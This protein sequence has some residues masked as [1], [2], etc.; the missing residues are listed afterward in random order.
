MILI[1]TYFESLL[2]LLLKY[3]ILKTKK[4]RSYIIIKKNI[5]NIKTLSIKILI[6]LLRYILLKSLIIINYLI[7]SLISRLL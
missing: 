3:I 2:F 4:I 1:E 7:K 6:K 5:I